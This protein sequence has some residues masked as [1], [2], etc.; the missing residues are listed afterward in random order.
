LTPRLTATP[1]LETERLIL[2]APEAKDYPAWESFFLA[3]RARF[4]GGGPEHDEGRAWRA[5][6][7]LIGHWALRGF[8]VFAIEDRRT[9]ANVGSVGPWF[10]AGWPE[11]EIGWTVWDPAFEGTGRMAEAARAVLG[12]V[13]RDL[14]WTTAVS[15]V[16][17]DNARSIALAERLGAKVDATA[18]APGA[19]DLVYR[20]PRTEVA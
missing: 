11:K 12:H 1:V 3:D 5:F 6:A 2:R 8:G 19:G 14:G 7:S 16:D 15:Y 9:R 18:R 4:V 20:H 10:P 17:R 13:F